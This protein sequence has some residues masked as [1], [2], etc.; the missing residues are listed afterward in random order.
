[1]IISYKLKNIWW[2]LATLCFFIVLW[3][4]PAKIHY[5]LIAAYTFLMLFEYTL[6]GSLSIDMI[7]WY[8]VI[9]AI[10]AYW[11]YQDLTGQYVHEECTQS[12]SKKRKH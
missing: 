2:Q 7:I 5:L 10:N 6:L 3:A 1:M 9:I 12:H 11:I 4:P 8:S